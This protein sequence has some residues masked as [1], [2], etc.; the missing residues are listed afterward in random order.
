MRAEGT[1]Y[2]CM[3]APSF[4]RAYGMA[5]SMS[6]FTPFT[7]PL[8]LAVTASAVGLVILRRQWPGLGH[9]LQAAVLIA[10]IFGTALFGRLALDLTPP[11]WSTFA[12]LGAGV[13]LP[14]LFG[15]RLANAGPD[16]GHDPFARKSFA[17]I[18]FALTLLVL[19]L[20]LRSTGS[21]EQVPQA[22]LLLSSAIP[23]VV[24]ITVLRDAHRNPS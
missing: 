21:D 9:W 12:T 18:L 13:L 3:N 17:G 10:S 8:C 4:V 1:G 20:A 24:G 2:D 19:A 6:T 11:P 22:L 15:I 5:S 7:E 14:P 16:T 23:A